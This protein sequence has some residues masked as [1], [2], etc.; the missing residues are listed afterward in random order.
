MDRVKRRS[1]PKEL[2]EARRPRG[3]PR[4]LLAL[5]LSHVKIWAFSRILESDFPESAVGLPFLTGYFPER[6]QVFSKHFGEHRLKREIIATGAANHVVNHAG[7]DFLSR[8]TRE[9]AGRRG[10]GR[11]YMECSR[12]KAREAGG[13]SGVAPSAR[14]PEGSLELE[15][16]WRATKAALAGNA[17]SPLRRRRFQEERR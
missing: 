9:T 11:S 8:M 10:R 15:G 7:V 1:V 13:D 3:L 14:N 12:A 16:V 4:P 17:S 2:L 6:L 5:V